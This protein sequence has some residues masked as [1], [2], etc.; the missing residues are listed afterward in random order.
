MQRIVSTQTMRLFPERFELAGLSGPRG[1]QFASSSD[2]FQQLVGDL[3][4][5][6]RAGLAV[7][8]AKTRGE[9]GAIDALVEPVP[10]PDRC[11]AALP[12]PL[13]VECKDHDENG[14]DLHKNVIE[15]WRRLSV[16][17]QEHAVAGWV[18]LYSPWRKARSYLYCVSARL[19]SAVQLELCQRIEA[20]FRGLPVASRV[21]IEAVE[22]LDWSILRSLCDGEAR[23]RD[24]W[25]GVGLPTLRGQEEQTASF[26]GFREYLLAATFPFVPPPADEPAHPDCL[27][28]RLS[29]SDERGLLLVGPGGV[30]K[31][32]TLV[33]V[34]QRA[35]E[36]GWRVLYTQPGEPALGDDELEEVVLAGARDTMVVFDYVEEL[37]LDFPRLRRRL[38][39][40][41]AAKGHRL[42]LA[43]NARPGVYA[44][45]Q[46]LL[47]EVFDVIELRPLPE[48]AEGILASLRER[49]AP[50]A[51]S[52]LG[53]ELF[54]Q[55]CGFRPIIALFLARELERRAEKGSLSAEA[56]S[57]A[58]PGHLVDWLRRRLEEDRLTMP[59]PTTLLRPAVPEPELE[60]AAAVLAA[61][62]Q[63][64]ENLQ[65]VAEDVLK[66]L[67]GAAE[68]QEGARYLIGALLQ[69]GWIEFRGGELTAAHDV[70]ADE[71]LLQ[72]LGGGTPL[73]LRRASFARLAA[74]A[75][76][77]PRTLGRLAHSLR[78]LL[79]IEGLSVAFSADLRAAA[80]EWLV[81]H[82]GAIAEA[83]LAAEA[84]EGSYALAG[85]LQGP[86]W[87]QVL[88]EKWSEIVSPWLNRYGKLGGSRH[89]L[90]RGLGVVAAGGQSEDLI[91][92]ALAWGDQHRFRLDASFVVAGLL[93]RADLG[94][95]SQLA[96]C[97]QALE[98]LSVHSVEE[99]A[100][101]VLHPLL[102]RTDLGAH[103]E[104]AVESAMAWLRA[105]QREESAQFVL[106]PL[107]ARTDLG[108]HAEAAVESAMAWLGVHQSEESAGF[109][110]RPL[111]A[112]TDLGAHAEAAVE[113]A[114]A[115][116]RAH[117]REESAQFV[118]PPLLA[119][120]DLGT[121]SEAA[122][123]SALAWLGVHQ[124]EESAG[125]VL[126]PLLARTDL[127][128]HAEAA[129]TSA[130][131]WLRAH[132]SEESAG[133]VLPPLL[134]RTD[135]GTH[136]GAA[137]E[138]AM[139]WL[140]A[141]QSEESAGFVLPPLLART[142]LGTH[143]DPATASALEWLKAHQSE[144]SAQFMLKALLARTDH[145]G[146]SE[147]VV[148]FTLAFLKTGA[149]TAREG[150][151]YVLKRLL[152]RT[153]L[154]AHSEA[155]VASAMSWL[156]AHQSEESAGFVLPPLLARVDLGTHAEAAVA[157]AMTWL[158]A[159]QSEESAGFVL[160]S[161]LARTDLGAHTEAAVTSARA[162]LE[163]GAGA[164]SSSDSYVLGR[165][166]DLHDLSPPTRDE[167]QTL[168][169]RWIRSHP[170]SPGSVHVL[171]SLLSKRDLSPEVERDA[172]VT[173]IMWLSVNEDSPRADGVFIRLL[174]RR[175]IEGKLRAL[176]SLRGIAW[177]RREFRGSDR[178]FALCALLPNLGLVGDEDRSFVLRD[179]LDW[180]ASRSFDEEATGLLIR[181]LCAAATGWP[182]E[183]DV[184]S[185]LESQRPREIS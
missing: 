45:R 177:L 78:R 72:V 104:A 65:V 63:S 138:S 31:S 19:P 141:H 24:R 30:G 137:V 7:R 38:L 42:F 77:R 151:D 75:V 3:L 69:L 133:F 170:R 157:S 20:F 184:R 9:D 84:D 167:T 139:A 81:E 33:E 51:S 111:L 61:A 2:A 8:V 68:V 131:T 129:A 97:V 53:A 118:L 57:G 121:H 164:A 54:R 34:G 92:A 107:L 117:Q 100:Q 80:A 153:D 176:A 94:Q 146:H 158:T 127:G 147:A 27:L 134:A 10:D 48:Q 1:E 116:L 91:R 161:L 109:V 115:W 120:T 21:P 110:L 37:R 132:Q 181:E 183:A 12:K 56:V 83:L 71:V 93:R 119:R 123:A 35:H 47:E 150:D 85:A 11:F 124:S 156:R 29:Q 39:P 95:E 58:R 130:L 172:V 148:A 166:L 126:R 16:R 180:L 90:Y 179:A 112:R 36:R 89:L 55:V 162:L 105:H 101:F 169:A 102:A 173:G 15:Q 106:H 142:D 70:V 152:R 113:S 168:A 140:G 165:L 136:S 23:L 67:R 14:R 128:A 76:Q 52:I 62:P 108:A 6:R 96:S 43:G 79:A 149:G 25:L 182:E 98:W 171:K 82:G 5:E 160:S 46:R 40:E 122:V 154:G 64:R 99:S 66:P 88:V 13:I 87:D 103:A 155:A 144:E 185:W 50:R 163:R 44:E 86:P 143:T 174:Q 28:E 159:H 26:R 135:L 49:V 4:V 125:F 74:P 17:L 114:M 32:R 145:G 22:V 18:D 175:A 178:H 73:A 59:P 60:A 41:V